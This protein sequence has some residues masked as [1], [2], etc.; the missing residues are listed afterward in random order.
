MEKVLIVDGKEYK[1]AELTFSPETVELLELSIDAESDNKSA[2]KC[3]S[4]AYAIMLDCM[5]RGGD[6]GTLDEAKDVLRKKTFNL[7][8]IKEFITL[9]MNVEAV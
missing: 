4:L 3:L 8:T 5:V 6:V 2:I 9:M 1:I 7:D